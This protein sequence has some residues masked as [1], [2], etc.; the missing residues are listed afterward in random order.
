MEYRKSEI[1]AG[2]FI[3]LS[4]I[5]FFAILFAI[6]GVSAWERKESFR[7]RFEYV[8]G[9]EPG[10]MVRFAGVPVGQVSAHRVLADET[11]PVELTLELSRGVPIRSDSYAYITSI[12]LLG[13]FYIEITPGTSHAERIK[14]GGLIPSREV[15]SFAQMSGPLGG[16]ASEATEL[17][18]RLNDLLNEGNRQNLSALI[19]NLN[20]LTA[21]NRSEL[22]ALIDNL[23]TL[24]GALNTTVTS[25]NTILAAN[26]TSLQR[27]LQNAEQLLLQVRTL[28]A[29]M[30]STMGD[31]DRIMVQNGESYRETFDNLRILSQNLTEFTRTIKEQPWSLV[32]KSY[33]DE[34]PLPKE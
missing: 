3:A 11:P 29:R 4:L 19:T 8:G 27:T 32:R 6:K 9:I 22:T 24:T 33:P 12:G 14:S 20:T 16:A 31:L 15:S 23:N 25:V 30:N 28:T 7:V 10:S 34:R 2:L 1:K 18:H 21:Q 17:L 5:L 26:D 13:A